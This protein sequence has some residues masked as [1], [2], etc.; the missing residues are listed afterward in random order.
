MPTQPLTITSQGTADASGMV[1]FTFGPV[2]QSLSWQGAVSI[3]GAAI[4][5]GAT[6]TATVGAQN[7]ATWYGSTASTMLQAPQGL[8]I[9]VTGGPLAANQQVT[10]SFIGSSSDFA[11]TTP[12]SPQSNSTGG[13]VG[14]VPTTGSAG[15]FS[16][17]Q[18]ITVPP[19]A[20]SAIVQLTSGAG[21]FD[22]RGGTTTGWYSQ[23]N[24]LS[25]TLFGA[26]TAFGSPLAPEIDASIT[27]ELTSGAAEYV[28]Y[29]SSAPPITFPLPPARTFTT[30]FSNPAVGL[31]T[32]L[33]GAGNA[34]YLLEGVSLELSVGG[35]ITSTSGCNAT[36]Q[37][38]NIINESPTLADLYSVAGPFAVAG[39]VAP[40]LINLQGILTYP[41]SDVDLN[42]TYSTGDTGAVPTVIYRQM[43]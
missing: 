21:L 10:A 35:T 19:W 6:W 36:V 7:W 42:V 8:T 2:P 40:V 5:A 39:I 24:A 31:H 18:T 38:A 11:T 26:L 29:F 33:P 4:P 3:S 1:S 34:C 14:T 43:M 25:Q 37:A 30:T 13:Q 12:L 15:P 23:F 41:G 32:L 17:S 20:Q 22:V 27:I 28:V 9:N 16:T